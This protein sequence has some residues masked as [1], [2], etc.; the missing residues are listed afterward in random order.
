[1][2]KFLILFIPI[3]FIVF[4]RFKNQINVLFFYEVLLEIKKEQKFFNLF[5]LYEKFIKD[6][7]EV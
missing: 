2:A 5:L 6:L 1:M 4:N 7:N 3:S